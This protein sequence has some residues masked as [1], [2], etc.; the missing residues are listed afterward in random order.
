MKLFPTSVIIQIGYDSTEAVKIATVKIV[1]G[2]T[3]SDTPLDS[4]MR[5]VVLKNLQ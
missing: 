2:D 1:D 4:N 3:K 5:G